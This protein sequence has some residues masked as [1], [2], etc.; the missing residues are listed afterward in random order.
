VVQPRRGLGVAVVGHRLG[1]VGVGCGPA[2][3][4]ARRGLGMAAGASVVGSV[5]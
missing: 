5:V 4:S 2:I 3:A 1:T